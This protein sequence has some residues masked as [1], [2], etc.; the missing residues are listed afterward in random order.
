M[1]MN[2]KKNLLLEKKK[3]TTKTKRKTSLEIASFKQ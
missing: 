3:I 2:E 1:K